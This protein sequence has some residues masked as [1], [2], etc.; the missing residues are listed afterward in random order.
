MSVKIARELSGLVNGK[1]GDLLVG[2]GNGGKVEGLAPGGRRLSPKEK[3]EILNRMWDVVD[4]Y[5]GAQHVGHFNWGVVEVDGVDILHCRIAASEDGPVLFKELMKGKHRLFVRAGGTCRPLEPSD[6]SK[7]IKKK[8]PGEVPRQQ[9]MGHSEMG[10]QRG[11]GAL[12]GGG[13][14]AGF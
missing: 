4:G 10:D 3:D 13:P 14:G 11:A 7:Y 1:G 5:F 2:V 9:T 6:E 12:A 8:W